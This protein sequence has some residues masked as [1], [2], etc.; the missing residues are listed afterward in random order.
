MIRTRLAVQRSRVRLNG[1]PPHCQ[2]AQLSRHVLLV[3]VTRSPVFQVEG[4][5]SVTVSSPPVKRA[6]ISVSDK[7]GLG[8]FAAGL[9]AAG[10][11]IYSTGGTRQLPGGRGFAGA[12]R[13]RVHRLSRDDGRPPEDVAPEIHGGILCRHDRPGRSG[14]AGRARHPHVRAGGRESLSVR[15]HGRP[16]GRHA[17]RRRSSRSTSAGRAWFA[18]RPRTTPSSPSPPIRRS[19]ARSSSRFTRQR[20]HDAGVAA[21]AGAAAPLAARAA[22]TR[23]SPTIC[24]ARSSPKTF[25]RAL[26]PGASPARSLALRR[27]PAPAGRPV[28]RAGRRQP[29]QPGGRAAIGGKELSYN[30]LLDL[31]SALAIAR[32]FADPAAVG[33]QAQQSLRRGLGG[34]AGR[35]H[36]QGDGTAIRSARSA[37]CWVSIARSTPPR[38]RCWPNRGCSSR[39]SSRP[40][41]SRRR[42]R[43][44]PR[45]RSGR[46]TCG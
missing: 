36:R 22:T 25:P 24:R 16:A 43:S 3:P 32:S 1:S 38:P 44:S 4:I 20:L 23:R 13:R 27:E 26:A 10:V 14:G 12:R 8:G 40:T 31:D 18:R 35:G 30:N 6:L 9:A 21:Q 42:W 34:H 46:P 39:R 37:R 7:L 29:R 5:Q 11:E 28:R 19:T 45:G 17:W 33:D 15:G 2:V 41:S